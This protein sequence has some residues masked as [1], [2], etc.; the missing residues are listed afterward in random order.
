MCV[1]VCV[2]VCVCSNVCYY[3]ASPQFT[4]LPV[5]SCSILQ[6]HCSTPPFPP[7]FTPT[8]P[9]LPSGPCPP[10]HQP[11]PLAPAPPTSLA[12]WP[13]PPLP[14]TRTV[15]AHGA[16]EALDALAA[17]ARDAIETDAAVLTWR[18]R[19]LVYVWKGEEARLSGKLRAA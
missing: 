16:V 3:R 7:Y 2:C 8:P 11:C 9:A 6:P 15:L 18:R 5:P 17:E 10:P 12:L 4:F 14:A 1:C 13:L 19:A